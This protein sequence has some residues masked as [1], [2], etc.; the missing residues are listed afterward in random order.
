MWG[1]KGT[2]PF[3]RRK[4]DV[5]IIGVKLNGYGIFDQRWKSGGG[6]IRSSI[7]SLG[8]RPDVYLSWIEGEYNWRTKKKKKTERKAI[9]SL[10]ISTSPFFF[11][12]LEPEHMAPALTLNSEGHLESTPKANPKSV[13]Q[14]DTQENY[15]GH[16]QFAPIEEAQVSRAMIKRSTLFE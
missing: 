10:S 13:A 11:V 9:L 8:K 14:T 5:K 12:P 3:H 2:P 4:R 6:L 7:D 16:Y 1:D 15:D